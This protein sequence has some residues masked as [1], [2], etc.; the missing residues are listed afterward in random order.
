MAG[1]IFHVCQ[2]PGSSSSIKS[3]FPTQGEKFP[4]FNLLIA[5]LEYIHLLCPPTTKFQALLSL[6]FTSAKAHPEG[7]TSLLG[8]CPPAQPGHE[9]GH[10]QL[11]QLPG[12]TQGTH[13]AWFCAT[14][15]GVEKGTGRVKTKVELHHLSSRILLPFTPVWTHVKP[16]PHTISPE[17]ESES[18]GGVRS[19]RVG[20][21]GYSKL[22]SFSIWKSIPTWGLTGW[23]IF[24]DF[25]P[26]Q[27]AFMLMLLKVPI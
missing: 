4:S 8:L 23:F 16:S 27:L 1:N 15:D 21:L 19:L 13:K 6:K 11:Q 25:T 5:Y 22:R 2:V 7:C 10:T 24:I 26:T 20:G 12:H 3:G 17:I 9:I 18:S 14:R